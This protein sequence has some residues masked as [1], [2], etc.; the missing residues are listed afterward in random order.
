M[1]IRDT[2]H[3]DQ[4]G[5]FTC[6]SKREN[7]YLFVTYAC[8]VNVILVRPLKTRKGK[9]VVYKL[10]ESHECLKERGCKSNHQFFDNETSS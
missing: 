4:T 10:S 6:T 2:I 9:E 5:K 7:S 1:D 8:D 3:T